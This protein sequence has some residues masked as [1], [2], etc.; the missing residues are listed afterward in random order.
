VLALRRTQGPDQIAVVVIF[1]AWVSYQVQSLISIDNLGIAVWGYI[2]GGALVGISI[3]PTQNVSHTQKNSLLQPTTSLFLVIISIAISASFLGK[4]TSIN[5]LVA[6]NITNPAA[7]QKTLVK[8]T[9]GPLKYFFKEP[10]FQIIL[11]ARNAQAGNF[12]EATSI[13]NKLNS[14]DSHNYEAR[15]LLAR[16]YEYKSNWLPAILVRRQIL[17]LDPFN[18]INLLSMGRDQIRVGNYVEANSTLALIESFAPNSP[19]AQKTQVEFKH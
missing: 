6:T 10:S 8:F 16:I 9:N 4:E 11:A 2:L 18:Q 17:V 13:L 15:E 12:S 19:K 1:A 14:S 5:R 3:P 7:D